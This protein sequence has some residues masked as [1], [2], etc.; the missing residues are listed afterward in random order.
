[1][2]TK[3]FLLIILAASVWACEKED[4]SFNFKTMELKDLR[5]D[6]DNLFSLVDIP[7]EIIRHEDYGGKLDTVGESKLFLRG[8][9]IVDREW[10][11]PYGITH[12]FYKKTDFLYSSFFYS[13]SVVIVIL[14]KPGYIFSDRLY[15]SHT[16]NLINFPVNKGVIKEFPVVIGE[17]KKARID[18]VRKVLRITYNNSWNFMPDLSDE[19]RDFYF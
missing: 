15:I 7:R 14:V 1:M 2:I 10:E 3:V 8:D 6:N 12:P 4:E 18:P 13:E 19:T 9:L 5:T 16:S 17:I 11:V